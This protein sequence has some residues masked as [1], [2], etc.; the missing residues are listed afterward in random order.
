MKFLLYGAYI[1]GGINTSGNDDW[2]SRMRIMG[3]GPGE[4]LY[5]E[6]TPEN[7][8]KAETYESLEEGTSE[9]G[10][11]NGQGQDVDSRPQA[12]AS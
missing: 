8:L 12:A 11:G 7:N 3:K 10:R 4:G 1:W 5:W 6:Q 9:E 2:Q